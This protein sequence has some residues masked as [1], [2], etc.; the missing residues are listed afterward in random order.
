MISLESPQRLGEIL[1][2]QRLSR[3]RD[4]RDVADAAGVSVQAL[5]RLERGEGSSLATAWAVADALGV[6]FHAK[7][8]ATTEESSPNRQRV[9]SPLRQKG[10]EDSRAARVSRELHRAVARKLR[11]N[12]DDIRS[13]ALDN[14][15]RMRLNARGALS[16]GWL[17]EWERML[18]GPTG[19]LIEFMLATGERADDLRQMT[20]FAGVLSEDERRDV[21]RRAAAA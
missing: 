1:R 4:Q 8:L 13:L 6:T 2:A 5:R 10:E 3:H 14:I 16:Q 15:A 7:G 20:P 18:D 11:S 12:P 9:S 17:D 21:V 19:E